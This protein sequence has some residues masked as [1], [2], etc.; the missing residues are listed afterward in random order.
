[1]EELLQ[2]FVIKENLNLERLKV[3]LH[4]FNPFDVLG[5]QHFEIRHSNFL[6]WMLDP[7]GSHNLGDYF[8]K[9][10]ISHMDKINPSYKINL[11]LTDLTDS[12]VYREWNNID[13]LII[14]DNLKF[15]IPIENKV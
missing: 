10:F 7:K 14:N 3:Q 11:F 2:S 5:V 1:M 15:V 8:L 4:E 13:I 12:R 6:A 9:G